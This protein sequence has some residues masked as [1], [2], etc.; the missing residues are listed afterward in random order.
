MFRKSSKPYILVTINDDDVAHVAYVTSD[1]TQKEK[2]L[3]GTFMNMCQDGDFRTVPPGR[4]RFQ[5]RRI[6]FPRF[7]Y[8]LIPID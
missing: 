4:Y 5:M 7:H 2:I 8:D 6:G 3:H 1:P